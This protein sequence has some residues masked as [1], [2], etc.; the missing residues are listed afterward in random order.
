MIDWQKKDIPNL[1]TYGRIAVIPLF[2]CVFYLPGVFG[3]WLTTLIF[4]AASATDWLDGYLARKWDVTSEKGRFLDPIADKLLV[5]S[6]LVLLVSESRAH[7]LP[8]IIILCRE[9]W[10]SGLR[11]FMGQKQVVVHVS[12]LAKWKTAT[13]MTAIPL[14]LLAGA[15]AGYEKIQLLGTFTLWG[16]AAVSALT[17]YQ[18]TKAAWGNL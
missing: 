13:Q 5:A 16:A 11:E 9:V 3:A 15:G 7:T 8:V 12:T 17:A 10:V 4:I 6:A 14:L 18:Y 1:F 2:V